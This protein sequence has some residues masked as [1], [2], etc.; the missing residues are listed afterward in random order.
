MSDADPIAAR[1]EI[2]LGAARA[3][4]E[5]TLHGL[6]TR[7]FGVHTKDDGTPVTD[8]DRDAERILREAIGAAFPDD[9]VLGEEF[10]EREGTSGYR[11][12]L[13]PID[14]T[15]SFVHGVPLYGTLVAV[16]RDGRSVAGVIHMP[17]LDETVHASEGGGAWHTVGGDE[18][19]R[20]RVSD[21]RDPKAGLF[22]TTSPGYFERSGQR[23][24]F[25]SLCAAFGDMRGWSDCYAHV[26]V[27]TGRAEI[28]VEPEIHPWDVAP[29]TVIM[30]EAGGRYTGWN[31]EESAY[32]PNGVA[33]NGHLHEAVIRLLPG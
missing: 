25:N 20:A 5:R 18:P 4:G 10:G 21:V 2:A 23:E 6:R 12:V 33:T 14:G 15:K 11:W 27:A 16:E 24:L 28:V 30:R 3:A 13:D 29:M 9:A 22:C 19:V 17:G 1:L 31:G 8:V 7:R 26:L 32:E